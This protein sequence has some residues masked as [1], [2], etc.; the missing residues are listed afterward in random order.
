MISAPEILA[1]PLSESWFC[2]VDVETSG[3]RMSSRVVEIGA[4][5]FN[6]CGDIKEF[7]TLINPCE[8]ISG[9][10]TEIH[11]ITDEMVGG[12]PLARDVL[13]DLLWFMDGCVF[14]A[15]NARFDVKMM[16]NELA[17]AQI[18]PPDSPVICTISLARKRIRGPA[19]Y[20]LETLVNFLA[21]DV[22]PLH[23]ALPDAHGARQVFLA[24]ID[25]M[26][27]ESPVAGVPGMLGRF[28][29][30]APPSV[31]E[32]DASGDIDELASLA[33]SRLT[34]EMDYETRLDRGPVVVT[35][36]RVFHSN[37]REYLKAYCHR[38][39]IP[40]TYRIDR[41]VNFRRV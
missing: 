3:M 28:P 9:W 12:S 40:K 33:E 6:L 29:V 39:G 19:N 37:E 11:G 21:E 15:H 36:L 32:I 24:G 17:R 14:V 18:E 8:P 23:N 20:R 31:E 30:V 41:I 7:Q 13:P 16:G 2:A 35:P 27:A 1:S 22:G 5:K 34:I 10:A 4:V 38:D 26:P 25:G